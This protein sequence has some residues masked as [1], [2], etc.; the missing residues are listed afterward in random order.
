MKL[1]DFLKCKKVRCVTDKG[2]GEDLTV[3]K[4]YKV[5]DTSVIIKV[6]DDEGHYFWRT[7]DRFEPV[8]ESAENPLATTPP[9]TKRG[10]R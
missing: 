4:E 6:L 7:Y 2:D 9:T 5:I 10:A 3:G 8:L 1:D